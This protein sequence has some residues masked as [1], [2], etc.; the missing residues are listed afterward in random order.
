[1]EKLGEGATGKVYKVL[2]LEN[3]V[4]YAAKIIKTG[5]FFLFNFLII[6][7]EKPIIMIIIW[8]I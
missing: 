6:C 5:I 8:K 1:M 7:V 3:N 4:E 2:H